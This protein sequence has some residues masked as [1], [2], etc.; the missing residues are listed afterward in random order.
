MMPSLSAASRERPPRY[1]SDSPGGPTKTGRTSAVSSFASV[2]DSRLDT[3]TW[4][5]F[6]ER[7]LFDTKDGARQHNSRRALGLRNYS[8]FHENPRGHDHHS[9]WS[10][11]PPSVLLAGHGSTPGPSNA[12][13]RVPIQARHSR[14]HPNRCWYAA[15]LPF[16]PLD[17]TGSTRPS[18]GRYGS[19]LLTT[20]VAAPFSD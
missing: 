7:H 8:P 20:R 16:S 15:P 1:P 19:S 2:G 11:C 14:R 6:S 13:H 10:F 18:K 3:T 9:S 12:G 17:S 4:T 5:S